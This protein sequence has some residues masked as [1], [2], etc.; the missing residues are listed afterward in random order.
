MSTAKT[1]VISLPQLVE[2]VRKQFPDSM[3]MPRLPIL[4]C[5][6]LAILRE[7]HPLASALNAL[8]QL[9]DRDNF[10]DWNEV[11]VSGLKEIQ[12][13]L[14]D[15][16][17]SEKRAVDLKRF[18]KELFRQNYK[19]DVEGISKK[20]WKEAKDE[21]A[22]YATLKNDHHLAHVQVLTFGGHAFPVD[23]R[24]LTLFQRLGLADAGAEPSS[25]RGVLE[26]NISKA[27][28]L[29][30]I[31]MFEKFV[32]GICT[33]VDPKCPECPLN[34]ICV[35]Y[36]R[37]LHPPK[38]SKSAKGTKPP[39]ESAT[40]TPI[41]PKPAGDDKK[42]KTKTVAGE[43]KKTDGK[44][45]KIDAKVMP[46]AEVTPDAP[47][48]TPVAVKGEKSATRNNTP[49]PVKTSG[50]SKSEPKKSVEAKQAAPAAAPKP[51]QQ[52]APVKSGAETK[53]K[54][55]KTTPDK[56]TAKVTAEKPAKAESKKAAPT[57]PSAKPKKSTPAPAAASKPKSKPKKK[58]K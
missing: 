58:S 27:Q 16:P 21:L 23:N 25:I 51:E 20:T 31:A 45:A 57:A 8:N 2:E 30:T 11:R 5:V 42:A 53:P 1:K 17:D 40:V 55:G 52:K 34:S 49:H 29:Q 6:I 38:P 56:S 54:A 43:S 26:K 19:F 46:V 14:A 48:K 39:T 10:F 47:A 41:E 4:E 7:N 15:Y 12:S 3:E 32:D 24:I 37:R 33:L 13:Y 36:Q 9:R 18:L 44:S 28:I 50:T 35:D 22:E